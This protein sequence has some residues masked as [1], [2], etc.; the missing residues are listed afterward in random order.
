VL[1]C[2]SNAGVHV[3]PARDMRG[4][5]M[6]IF[7]TLTNENANPPRQCTARLLVAMYSGAF[8]DLLISPEMAKVLHLPKE[9]ESSVGDGHRQDGVGKAKTDVHG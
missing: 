7:V 4:G 2:L 9:G 1:I 3:D 6:C 5:P 8:I